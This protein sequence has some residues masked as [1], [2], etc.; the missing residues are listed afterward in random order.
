MKNW[1]FIILTLLLSCSK[2]DVSLSKSDGIGQ[3]G[4]MARFAIVANTLYV[5]T[6]YS[7]NVYDITN[8]ANPV[9]QNSVYIG[10][11]IETIFPRDINYLFI[12]SSDGIYI[13]N[14]TDKRNPE[15]ISAYWH[16]TACD[17]VVANNKTAYATLR[18]NRINARCNRNINEL[19]AV[20][21]TNPNY[22]ELIKSYPMVGP[23][24]LGLWK[25]D[26]FVCDENKMVR[27]NA[28][29]PWSLNVKQN[30]PVYANDII[31]KDSLLIAIGN[32]G[33]V[34]YKIYN[35]SL[36]FLSSIETGI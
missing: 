9:F 20:D 19:I 30:L 3:G 22:P 15:Y 29:N 21:I 32:S 33:L 31:I 6:N 16:S 24:G 2:S 14:I 25:D 7:L 12:G 34:Q 13:Y 36:S 23:K 26:L 4:S 35:D 28:T 1:L 10:R 5:V 18:S 11:N 27:Y 17:P 8:I